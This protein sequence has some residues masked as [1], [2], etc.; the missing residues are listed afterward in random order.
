MLRAQQALL[1]RDLHKKMVLLTGP[2]QVGKT[3]LAMAI[4]ADQPSAAAS[5]KDASSA[6]QQTVYLNYDNF[7][8][9][10]I[11]T[12]MAWLPD[13]SLLVLDEL[14]KMPGWK[15]YLKGLYDTKPVSLQILVTG[16]ARLETFRH[17]GDSLA[18]RF[19]RHRLHPLSMAEIPAADGRVLDRLME[20]GGFPEPYLADS[21]DDANRWRLHYV[22]G[23]IRTD[24]LDFEKVHDFKAMQTTLQLL[25][26]RVGSPLSFS[27]LARDVG[28]APNTI[29]RYVEVLEALFI[30][31]RVTPFHRN[32]ARSLLKEP[33]L[34]FYDTGMVL[35]DDGIRFENLVATALLKHLH[36]VEDTKGIAT[37]LCVLRTKEKREVDFVLVEDEVPVSMIEVKLS[38]SEV[39][40]SLRYFH[41]RYGI[42]AIQL[43]KNLRQERL[44]GEIALRR[45]ES[46]LTGLIA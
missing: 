20:R 46:F 35:G 16:S 19:F 26:R 15:N 4:A 2:R 24:I 7:E 30:V 14:H 1:E 44:E 11:I 38:D 28:C 40:A 18:G 3:H 25:R 39:S 36:A 27:S 10:A 34:Y 12:K 17:S 31:F 32:I 43:V 37:S 8:D 45:A 29:K 5:G 22:D 13:T 41:Q 42:P 33:K 23:L 9:R 21:L 6:R